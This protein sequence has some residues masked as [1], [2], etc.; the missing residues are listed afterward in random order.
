MPRRCGVGSNWKRSDA[1]PKVSQPAGYG[2]FALAGAVRSRVVSCDRSGL[3]FR[4][5]YR[6]A[7]LSSRSAQ[8]PL[9]RSSA[10]ASRPLGRN[11]FP[12]ILGEQ[13]SRPG[14]DRIAS[15]NEYS[16]IA[17]NSEQ[18]EQ[19]L[20]FDRTIS[21]TRLEFASSSQCDFGIRFWRYRLRG[22][23]DL[24][25]A[26][27]WQPSG[28]RSFRSLEVSKS[29]L[30]KLNYQKT[31]SGHHDFKMIG[32]RGSSASAISAL[33]RKVI[34]TTNAIESGP[35][36]HPESHGEARGV[37]DHGLGGEDSIPRNAK[38]S[39]RWKRPIK[40]WSTALNHLAIAFEKRVR[41]WRD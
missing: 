40:Y 19:I 20:T 38:T 6:R 9:H 34:Y 8:A 23:P 31:P 28:G 18:S 32:K 35:R 11:E 12:Q 39:E 27:L 36:L 29:F 5:P 15:G 30:F 21:R 37:F 14:H 16:T 10:G 3:G 41:R 4:R 7:T 22:R 24:D 25:E 13:G 33:I 2:G 17:S 26:N 1:G